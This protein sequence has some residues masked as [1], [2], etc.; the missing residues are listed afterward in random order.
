[1]S[2]ADDVQMQGQSW[3]QEHGRK[4]W[5]WASLTLQGHGR[6]RCCTGSSQAAGQHLTSWP[7][8]PDFSLAQLHTLM[9]NGHHPGRATWS[10]QRF[11]PGCPHSAAQPASREA[12][13]HP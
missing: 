10:E 4:P 7:Q 6:H 9:L 5:P 11:P 12:E 2:H 3:R 8:N 1:M 13:V